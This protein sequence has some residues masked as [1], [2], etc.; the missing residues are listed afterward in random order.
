MGYLQFFRLAAAYWNPSHLYVSLLAIGTNANL[1]ILSDLIW[2]SSCGG[3]EGKK[4]S[5]EIAL[6]VWVLVNYT[7]LHEN[8]GFIQWC[9]GKCLTVD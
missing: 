4:S 3:E 6:K 9:A 1:K 5:W 7:I 2:M 8:S